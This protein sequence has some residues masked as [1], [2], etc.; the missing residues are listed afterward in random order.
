ME[1]NSSTVGS[2]Q[3]L[4]RS[5]RFLAT[6]VASMYCFSA[7]SLVEGLPGPMISVQRSVYQN[8][9]SSSGQGVLRVIVDRW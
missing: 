4:P 3:G 9:S 2:D 1:V 6:P 5:L 7:S 8:A